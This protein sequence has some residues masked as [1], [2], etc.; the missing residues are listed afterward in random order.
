MLTPPGERK[1]SYLVRQKVKRDIFG[2]TLGKTFGGSKKKK[3]KVLL[4]INKIFYSK[5]GF[6]FSAE[7]PLLFIVQAISTS[8]QRTPPLDA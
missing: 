8:V 7:V 6:G 5:E 3:N 2:E 1:V 4:G